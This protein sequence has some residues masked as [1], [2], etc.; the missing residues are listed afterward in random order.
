MKVGDKVWLFDF[1]RRVY[2]KNGSISNSPIYS[3]YF[4]QATIDGE[5]SRSWI[6]LC[7]KFPKKN[8][9]GLYTDK[10]KA[11]KI[12]VNENRY[13]IVKLV[14]N[15]SIEKLKQIEELFK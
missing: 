1:N 14:E 5:T 2:P 10:Q 9:I 13:R 12:W 15:C 4:Y 11:D 3:E 6:V 7:Q 8:P